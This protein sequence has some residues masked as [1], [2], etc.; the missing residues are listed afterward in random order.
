MAAAKLGIVAGSGELPARLI[1]A[2]RAENR[3]FFVLALKGAA[4]PALVAG[5]PHAWI[6]IGQGGEGLRLLRANGVG[7]LVLAGGV[8]RPSPWGLWPDWRAVKFYL[9]IGLKALGDD[10]LLRS[11]IKALEAEG[12]HVVG[13]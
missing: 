5:V 7:E 3:P 1:A 8:R 13:A 12:F 11:V 9:A 4:D 10:G 2:C 6:R